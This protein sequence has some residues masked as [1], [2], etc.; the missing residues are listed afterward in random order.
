[1]TSK[2]FTPRQALWDHLHHEHGLTL[3]LSEVDEIERLAK[4]IPDEP[5]TPQADEGVSIQ[6]VVVADEP[7]A[8]LVKFKVGP[9]EFFIGR[10]YCENR[11]HAEWFAN[12]FRKALRAWGVPRRCICSAHP[13]EGFWLRINCP[14]HGNRWEQDELERLQN[15]RAAQPPT[16]RDRLVALLVEAEGLLCDPQG[17]WTANE[18][19]GRIR[20]ALTKRAL[21]TNPVES[22]GLNTSAV[23]TSERRWTCP[24]C[25]FLNEPIFRVCH[26]CDTPR[27]A[28]SEDVSP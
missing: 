8:H 7:D 5:S 28:E 1:M 6:P 14:I 2:Q 16:D 27:P 21:Y 20:G 15:E 19:A 4:L 11:E 9:Q 18:L 25:L 26:V 10:E 23:E 13:I 3:V 12:M 17:G 24:K 22:N